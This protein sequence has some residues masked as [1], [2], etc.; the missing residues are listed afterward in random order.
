MDGD[1]AIDPL[2]KILSTWEKVSGILLFLGVFAIFGH[3]WDTPELEIA[4]ST[5][6]YIIL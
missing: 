2:H 4:L 5:G 6:L 1:P 3:N